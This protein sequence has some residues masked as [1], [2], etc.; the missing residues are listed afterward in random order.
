M[1]SA[2]HQHAREA[3]LSGSRRRSHRDEFNK[4]ADSVTVK[5]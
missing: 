1:Q 4:I 3:H 5:K 2:S